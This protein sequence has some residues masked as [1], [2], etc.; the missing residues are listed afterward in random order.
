MVVVLELSLAIDVAVSVAPLSTLV[1][2][3]VVLHTTVTYVDLPKDSLAN[4]ASK[5]NANV[6]FI[7]IYLGSFVSLSLLDFVSLVKRRFKISNQS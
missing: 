7:S 2:E 1:D 3:L 5:A 6:N 4:R